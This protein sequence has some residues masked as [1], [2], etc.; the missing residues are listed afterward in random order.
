MA[1]DSAPGTSSMET[2]EWSVGYPDFQVLK[3]PRRMP[4]VP[5]RLVTLAEQK[6]TELEYFSASFSGESYFFEPWVTVYVH[7]G[8]SAELVGVYCVDEHDEVSMEE[9]SVC[10]LRQTWDRDRDIEQAYAA[11]DMGGVDG[12]LSYITDGSQIETTMNFGTGS[13]QLDLLKSTDALISALS[14][15][16]SFDPVSQTEGEEGVGWSRVRFYSGDVRLLGTFDYV[17]GDMDCPQL[18]TYLPPWLSRMAVLAQ[19]PGMTPDEKP[20]LSIHDSV[21]EVLSDPVVSVPRSR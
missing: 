7:S 3:P 10:L 4:L 11:Y 19:Q 9:P 13:T 21:R 6:M 8:R 15:G 1:E 18:T 20:L 17:P 2:E 12:F 16:M 5:A 14:R